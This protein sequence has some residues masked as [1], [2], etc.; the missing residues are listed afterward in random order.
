MKK[1]ILIGLCLVNLA[2]VSCAACPSADL[3][4]D[5]KVDI[6]DF[7]QLASGWLTAYSFNDFVD[8]AAGWL[9]ES[10]SGPDIVWVFV[11]DDGS[12]MVDKNGNPIIKG[13]FSGYIS[14]YETSN[15]DFCQFLNDALS[16]GDIE[17][18]E[19]SIVYGK[20]GSNDGVDYAG[21]PY[22]DTFAAS[23]ESQITYS[24]GVDGVFSVRSRDGYDMSDHPV[25]MVSWYGATAFASYYRWRLPTE[26]EWQAV[27]DYD[28]SYHYGCGNILNTSLANYWDHA[29]LNPLGFTVYPYTTPLG[30]Y[31]DFGY[32]LCDVA[33]NVFEWT[34]SL[35]STSF[36]FMVFR[37]G[38]WSGS[39]GTCSAAYRSGSF[40]TFR[41]YY[42]GF[43]V[44]REQ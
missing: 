17:V 44:C 21:E 23:P 6:E 11:D 19:D 7:S 36:T 4:G 25:V 3:T 13:G 31:G 26:W 22:F 38:G 34:S 33:G 32:G 39:D 15:A 37:G 8:V 43:R 10:I 40:P 5:C 20:I 9:E 41:D 16:S 24:G 42:C 14:K 29:Y 28:G 35:Y 30:Y 2:G 12:G 1:C 18:G 27:A